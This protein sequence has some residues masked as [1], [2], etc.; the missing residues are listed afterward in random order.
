MDGG[1]LWAAVHGVARS[2]TWLSTFIFTF[3]F[4]ALE[5][6]MA[7]HSSSCL[8]NPMSKGAWG[9]AVHGVTRSWTRLKRLSMHAS[10][11]MALQRCPHANPWN[12]WTCYFT[13][14][15]GLFRCTLVK[16]LELRRVSWI[17][18][19]GLMTPQVLI[20]GG[21]RVRVRENKMW[22]QPQKS[23]R[24]SCWLGPQAKGWGGL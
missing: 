8:E 6:E 13:W 10:R 23:E 21:R 9:A 12:L 7:T 22:W 17:T 24:R 2:R 16:H 20:Q 1:D 11:I 3:H 5:K 14:Q 18:Q 4:H 15:K 19:M